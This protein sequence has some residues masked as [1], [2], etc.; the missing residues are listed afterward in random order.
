MA[1]NNQNQTIIDEIL[2]L[3]K[4]IL[5][6]NYFQH[7]DHF[8]KPNKGI[9]IGSPISGTLAEIYLQSFERIYLKHY[10]ENKNI[11]Y[12]KRYVD[13]L[14]II[15]DHTKINADTIHD[16]T[17]SIDVHLEFKLTKEGN[18]I[19]N[20]LDLSIQRKHNEFQLNIYRKPTYVDITIH[21]MSNHPRLHKM[22]GF[23]F[24][25][26]RMLHIFNSKQAIKQ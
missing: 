14:I 10:L 26:N 16:I 3:L 17:D 2:Y 18:H 8:Y 1:Q 21:F 19:A 11:I 23:H 5:E 20:Y 9:A 22:A 25:I 12:Y 15:Y 4:I 24:Y 6:Q 7:E 13:D